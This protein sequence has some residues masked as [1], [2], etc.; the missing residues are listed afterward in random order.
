MRDIFISKYS[1]LYI[2]MS[3]SKLE[4]KIEIRYWKKIIKEAKQKLNELRRLHKD[5]PQENFEYKWK[6]L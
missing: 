4:R 1:T 2:P 5:W 3:K 6:Q